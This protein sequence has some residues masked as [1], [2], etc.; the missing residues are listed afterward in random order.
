MKEH[1]ICKNYSSHTQFSASVLEGDLDPHSII[2]SK[3][4]LSS[5]SVVD[6]RS[7]KSTIVRD[8]DMQICHSLRS[9]QIRQRQTDC[10]RLC[11]IMPIPFPKPVLPLSSNKNGILTLRSTRSTI[12][13]NQAFWFK[14]AEISF[15]IL[16]L[17]YDV[18]TWLICICPKPEYL[19][20]KERYLK[21]VNSILLLAKTPCLWLR[22]A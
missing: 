12:A 4:G 17:V 14:L 18:I 15:F 7:E 9:K 10:Y 2:A 11:E 8:Q 6:T 20:N 3:F 19:W 13:K 1:G 21:I 5:V 16:G 22:I